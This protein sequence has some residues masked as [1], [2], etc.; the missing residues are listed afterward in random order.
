MFSQGVG[1]A[2]QLI[3]GPAYL[4]SPILSKFTRVIR[5]SLPIIVLGL[6]YV[7]LVE[8]AD[9]SVIYFV[10]VLEFLHTCS[11]FVFK[12]HET[13][14]RRQWAFFITLVGSSCEGFASRLIT[15]ALHPIIQILLHPVLLHI[16][17]A[18]VG[19]VVGLSTN[20]S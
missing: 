13:E 3:R 17:I 20:V 9:Y 19:V 12:A 18:L 5:K 14:Y 16:P 15:L 8:G 10:R 11:I 1:S 6:I 7:I 2:T 4:A